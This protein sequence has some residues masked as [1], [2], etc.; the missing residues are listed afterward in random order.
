MSMKNRC[1]PDKCSSAMLSNFIWNYDATKLYRLFD[2]SIV[3][4]EQFMSERSHILL[5]LAVLNN[6]WNHKCWKCSD[7]I[8]QTKANLCLRDLGDIIYL[9][10]DVCRDISLGL[11]FPIEHSSGSTDLCVIQCKLYRSNMIL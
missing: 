5:S 6:T 4:N 10:W 9:A 1:C 2:L 7:M 11:F 3:L 8:M